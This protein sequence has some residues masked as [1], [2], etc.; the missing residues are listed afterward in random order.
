MKPGFQNGDDKRGE[1]GKGGIKKPKKVKNGFVNLGKQGK[2]EDGPQG[3][4]GPGNAPDTRLIKSR[5][6]ILPKTVTPI[7]MVGKIRVIGGHKY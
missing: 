1:S 2:K 7:D 5:R 6:S 3:L 4:I